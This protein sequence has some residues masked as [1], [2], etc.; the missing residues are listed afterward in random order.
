ME[1]HDRDYYAVLGVEQNANQEQLKN[2]YHKLAKKYHSDLNSEDPELKKWSH[3]MMAELN[4]AYSTLKDPAKRDQYDRQKDKDQASEIIFIESL[5]QAKEILNAGVDFFSFGAP[6]FSLE[7]ECRKE[8]RK[9]I[10]KKP[11]KYIK[12]GVP[13]E[14][15]KD[16]LIAS[17]ESAAM[18]ALERVQ[19]KTINH[20]V[21]Q[22]YF[23]AN[24]ILGI[25]NAFKT[26]GAFLD[27]VGTT[28]LWVSG[29]TFSYIIFTYLARFIARGFKSNLNGLKGFIVNGGLAVFLI[30]ISVNGLFY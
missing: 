6:S 15:S 23:Y 4:D 29:S 5:E 14:Y 11:D 2:M 1:K 19:E 20:T 3:E 13:N 16:Y 25:I 7:E 26:S 30:I 9:L 22:F 28:L 27:G 18:E 24:L 17:I 8:T 10:N 12:R 21:F